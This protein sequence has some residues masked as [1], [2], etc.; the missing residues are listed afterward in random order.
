M[1]EEKEKDRLDEQLMKFNQRNGGNVEIFQQE[2][3][4][5]LDEQLQAFI[6]AAKTQQ[7]AQ[8]AD[9]AADQAQGNEPAAVEDQADKREVIDTN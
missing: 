9:N 3:A 8:P 4:N 1:W 2:K 6:E 5:K 7:E